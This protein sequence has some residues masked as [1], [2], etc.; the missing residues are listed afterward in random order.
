MNAQGN[1]F[2]IINNM[3][4]QLSNKEL[5]KIANKVCRRKFSL[6]ADGLLVLEPPRSSQGMFTMRLFNADGS[7]GEMCGNGARC[8]AWY[9]Y[10]KG[11]VSKEMVID[12]ISGTIKAWI[13]GKNVIITLPLPTKI[14]LIKKIKTSKG[15]INC[16]YIELGYPGLPHVVIE[17]QEVFKENLFK[18]IENLKDF[19]KEIRYHEVFQKGT[20]VNFYH[21]KDNVIYLLTYER[22]VEDFTLACG[23]GAASTVISLAKRGVLTLEKQNKIPVKVPGGELS[24]ILEYSENQIKG[25]YLEGEIKYIAE[26][27]LHEDALS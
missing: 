6:G 5:S 3:N 7:E 10:I 16:S 27:I 15:I 24:I 17:H 26:G 14:E 21:I 11:L 22:G 19:A 13:N 18:L 8:I 4:L 9:A 2:I 25:I 1:D 23:T 20:N 12:T